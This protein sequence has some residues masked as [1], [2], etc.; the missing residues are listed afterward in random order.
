MGVITKPDFLVPGSDTESM[1]VL[2][3]ENKEFEL[4][5]GWHV[6]RRTSRDY[7]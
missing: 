6:R 1:F 5:F 7:L 3:A 4:S 2:L